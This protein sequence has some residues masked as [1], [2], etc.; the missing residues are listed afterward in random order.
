VTLIS[1]NLNVIEIEEK[2]SRLAPYNR[3]SYKRFK[4]PESSWNLIAQFFYDMLF[5]AFAN[6]LQ[7][8]LDHCRTF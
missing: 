1:G 2:L 5:G 7:A 4:L 8:R 3:M 6:A